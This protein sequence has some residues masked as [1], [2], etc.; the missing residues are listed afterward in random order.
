MIRLKKKKK[1]KKLVRKTKNN[2][3]QKTKK[4]RVRWEVPRHD[5]VG[6]TNGKKMEE[7]WKPK[8]IKGEK[9]L[10]MLKDE[11]DKKKIDEKWWS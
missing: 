3:N 1:R 2:E 9:P 6:R 8:K 10:G 4:G 5:K 7:I 11:I